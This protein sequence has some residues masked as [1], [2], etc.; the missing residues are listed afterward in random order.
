MAG[1]DSAPPA[2]AGRRL[3][4][5]FGNFCFRYRDALFPIVF[6]ALVLASPPGTLYGSRTWDRLL[7]ALGIAV[8]LAGQILRALVIGLA[9]IRR[10]GLNK[11]VHADTLVV[12][13]LFAHSR[14][15]LYFGNFLAFVGFSLIHNSALC[16]LVGILFFAL[17]YLAIVAAEE[18]FLRRRFGA[19]FDAYCR[20][21]NRFLPSLRGLGATITGRTFD[22]RRLLRKEYGSTFAGATVILSLLIW[23]DVRRFGYQA[24]RGTVLVALA[25]WALMIPAYLAARRLKKRGRL[26]TGTEESAGA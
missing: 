5:G 20:K 18:E 12:E 1:S 13:G 7:D 11:R 3:L 21:V 14:N 26:G 6:L 8:A 23:D 4:V 17:A 16:Y 24:S 2:G 19:D 22:W 25:G 15:P 9:Y 10:G